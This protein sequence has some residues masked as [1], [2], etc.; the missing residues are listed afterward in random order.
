MTKPTD[1]YL[2]NARAAELREE[3]AASEARL[4]ERIRALEDRPDAA[5]VLAEE[6]GQASLRALRRRTPPKKGTGL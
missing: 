4:G 2:T 3:I 5:E 6:L 1:K